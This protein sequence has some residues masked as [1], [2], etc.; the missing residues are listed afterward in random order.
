MRPYLVDPA[1]PSLKPARGFWTGGRQTVRDDRWRLIVHPA[2]RKSGAY[3]ELFDYR[4]DPEET[5]NHAADL[6]EVVSRLQAQLRA[7]P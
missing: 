5:R 2:S 7:A 4:N 6:P 1:K 3:V